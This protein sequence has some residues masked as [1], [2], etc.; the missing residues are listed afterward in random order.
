MSTIERPDEPDWGPFL[1]WS[2]ENQ[3]PSGPETLDDW[4][5]SRNAVLNRVWAAWVL[6]QFRV[7]E[8]SDEDVALA[9]GL[10]RRHVCGVCGEGDDPDCAE[11]C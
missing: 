6:P 3:R 8:W 5:R 11:R 2:E 1:Q 7:S 4:L 10:I 9:A